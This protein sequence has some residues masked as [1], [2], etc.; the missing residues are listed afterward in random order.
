LP[1]GAAKIRANGWTRTR[2]ADATALVWDG[3]L[4]EDMTLEVSWES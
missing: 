2:S 3:A 4:K 1:E